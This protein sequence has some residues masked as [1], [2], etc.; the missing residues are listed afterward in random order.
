MS[1]VIFTMEP[2]TC[3]SCVKKIEN[4]VARINGVQDVQVMFNSGRVRAE[5][6]PGSTNAHALQE[7]IERL[8]YPVLSKKES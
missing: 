2:F 8:G 7:T 4:A 3:P 5:F 1:K 6:D